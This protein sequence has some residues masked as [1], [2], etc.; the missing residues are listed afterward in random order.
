MARVLSRIFGRL[1]FCC[2]LWIFHRWGIFSREFM[3]GEASR[4]QKRLPTSSRHI[5]HKSFNHIFKLF[6]L[7]KWNFQKKASSSYSHIC[8]DLY[9]CTWTSERF[10]S[11]W[12]M[13][14]CVYDIDEKYC[15]YEDLKWNVLASLWW[16]PIA[17][18][19]NNK[20]YSTLKL[21]KILHCHSNICLS[22]L[23]ACLKVEIRIEEEF[24]TIIIFLLRCLIHQNWCSVHVRLKTELFINSMLNQV[25]IVIN[26]TSTLYEKIYNNCTSRVP[27]HSTIPACHQAEIYCVKNVIEVKSIKETITKLDIISKD[28]TRLALALTLDMLSVHYRTTDV[29]YI[30]SSLSQLNI[31]WVTL[32]LIF[33]LSISILSPKTTTN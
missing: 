11:H 8:L 7:L 16:L 21:S 2:E 28:S 6:T 9:Y 29:N 27:A 18:T 33:S 23:F 32:P 10:V 24:L 1:F 5:S 25:K 15:Y 31:N 14:F 3:A 13:F 4:Q 17:S 22:L 19:S 20:H 12:S 30:W 26:Y